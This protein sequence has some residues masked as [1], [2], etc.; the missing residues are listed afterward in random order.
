MSEI[1]DQEAYNRMT[2]Y[3]ATAE[4]CRSEI[5][6]KLQR[7]GIAYTSIDA[8]VRQLEQEGFIDEER[9][10]KA[11]VNDKFRLEHWGKLKIAQALQVKKIAPTTY[12][13]FVNAIDRTEYM[14]QLSSLLASKRKSIHADTERE[15]CEK[16]MR[17][18][19]S[20][21]YEVS[22]ILEVV[23]GEPS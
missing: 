5:I 21:G 2:Q 19:A 1:T 9:Y 16:L 23:K 4:H 6:D 7:W 13:P 14:A 15:R 12:L 17:F 3:C 22:D 10:C 18:A 11:F 8:I 20:R